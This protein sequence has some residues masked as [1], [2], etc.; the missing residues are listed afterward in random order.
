MAARSITHPD[1]HSAAAA[2][3][4]AGRGRRAA[5]PKD[6]PAPGW[7]DILVRVKSSIGSDHITLVAAGLAMCGLLAVF[8]GLAASIA[9]YGLI[10]SPAQVVEHMQAFSGILPP[11]TWDLFKTQLQTVAEQTQGSLTFAALGGLLIALWSARAGMSALMTATNIAYAEPEKRG[12]FRQTFVS[13][14]FTIGA[15]VGF[16][17][18]LG[19]GVVLPV[20]LAALRYELVDQDARRR[21]ALGGLVG[22][23][24]SGSGGVVSIRA[25]ASP[26]PVALGHLG[27]CDCRHALDRRERSVC[28]V[29]ERICIVW[30]NVRRTRRRHRAVDVVL[31]EQSRGRD[32][33]GDQLGDGAPDRQDTTVGPEAPL[34]QRGAHSADT[35]GPTAEKAPDAREKELEQGAP[36]IAERGREG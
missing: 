30:K 14:A 27:F 29:R 1:A 24:D 35:V 22:R 2:D 19:L 31:S 5:D 10:A 23:R 32:R 21:P 26:G 9:L 20:A 7:R 6:I 11:G 34:G 15:I 16:L 12:F 18:V 3:T 4:E 25:I 36:A 13:L 17:L 8:P 33:R 28:V